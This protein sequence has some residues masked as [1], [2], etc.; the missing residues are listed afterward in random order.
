MG[1]GGFAT[2]YEAYDTQTGKTI[3]LK[4]F[5]GNETSRY[6]L[7]R[8]IEQLKNV[9]IH[10]NLIQYFEVFE[11]ENCGSDI[12]GNALKQQVAV[13]EFA[14]HK[15]LEELMQTNV[16]DTLRKHLLQDILQ[17]L[18]HLHYHN[19]V[20]RDLKPRNILI[21]N[22]NGKLV[23]KITDFGI[24]KALEQ[25]DAN[26]TQTSTGI[27]G[28]SN[29]LAPEQIAPEQFAENGKLNE[30]I[31]VWSFGVFVY[32][33]VT[34]NNLYKHNNT[35]SSNVQLINAVLQGV[36]KEQ[37]QQLPH[38]YNAITQKCLIQ[39]AN[40]RISVSGLIEIFENRVITNL[41]KPKTIVDGIKITNS[42]L[43]NR[44][45]FFKYPELILV[46]L[47]GLVGILTMIIFI[48]I[49][50]QLTDTWVVLGVLILI[51][52]FMINKTKN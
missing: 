48:L 51:L 17:G 37:L 31:D 35:K 36:Q 33:W 40:E 32:E 38:P 10:S 8:E 44:F 45:Q 21:H 39:K 4:I 46:V 12:H 6:N 24:A 15:T 41:R 30:K 27:I 16:P 19:I 1:K 49:V 52:V 20:H 34:S 50:R 18:Q 42:N 11:V 7:I 2:V 23:A 26:S 3:A 29:Y 14:N 47:F 43:T 13:L 22:Q 9:P 5:N 28:T 25:T